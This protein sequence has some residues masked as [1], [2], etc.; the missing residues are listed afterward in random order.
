MAL[1]PCTAASDVHW[2]F[3]IEDRKAQDS[4]LCAARNFCSSAVDS[5]KYGFAHRHAQARS[6]PI[7]LGRVQLYAVEKHCIEF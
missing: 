1:L 3:G 2:F 7:H 5:I 4:G 6:R